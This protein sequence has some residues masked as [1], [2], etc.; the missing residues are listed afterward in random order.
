MASKQSKHS[1]I[2]IFVIINHLIYNFLVIMHLRIFLIGGEL[3]LVFQMSPQLHHAVKW[4][5]ANSTQN[6]SFDQ[7]ISAMINASESKALLQV[8]GYREPKEKEVNWT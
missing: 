3:M 5:K 6:P 8:F 1:L 4:T 2:L 7:S